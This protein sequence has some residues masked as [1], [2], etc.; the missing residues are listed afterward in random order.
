MQKPMRNVIVYLEDSEL[1]NI[2]N[3]SNE[4]GVVRCCQWFSIIISGSTISLQS[5]TFIDDTHVC[6]GIVIQGDSYFLKLFIFMG[7]HFFNLLE[8]Q[9][10]HCKALKGAEDKW[11]FH[12][13][14]Q[15]LVLLHSIY[16]AM[17]KRTH[18]TSSS[19]LKKIVIFPF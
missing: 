5:D 10:M 4:L 13:L 16:V 18:Y 19:K 14:L 12:F 9:D 8:L 2:I 1:P 6:N 15:A 3:S 11:L 17:T 7:E